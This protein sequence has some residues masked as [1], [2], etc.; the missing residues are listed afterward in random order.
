MAT[1]TASPNALLGTV[2]LTV[3]TA[4]GET[5]TGIQRRDVNGGRL[6]RLPAGQVPSSTGFSVVDAEGSLV[7]RITYQIMLSTGRGPTTSV[8]IDG[9]GWFLVD[10]L[11]PTTAVPLE[12]VLDY[13]AQR[14]AMTIFHDVIGR[15]DPVAAIGTLR[16]RSG[17]LDLWTRTFED[18]TTV[19]TMYSQKRTLLLRQGNYAGMDLYHLPSTVTISP[20][21]ATTNQRRWRVSIQYRE[22]AAPTGPLLSAIGWTYADVLAGYS[23]YEELLVS[24]TDYNALYLNAPS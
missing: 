1:I 22:V 14:D 3:T 9:T 4:G 13:S 24:F 19:S 7:G 16:M 12:L 18:A 8:T 10:P 21:P 15:A 11:L 6:V 2:A 23:T 17:S 20:D 5:I